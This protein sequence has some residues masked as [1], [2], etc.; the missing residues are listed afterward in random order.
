MELSSLTLKDSPRGI[1]SQTMYRSLSV[2][3]S[4][5]RSGGVASLAGCKSQ[6][7][8][9]LDSRFGLRP[10]GASSWLQDSARCVDYVLVDK[11]KDASETKSALEKPRGAK[12]W[13]CLWLCGRYDRS[14]RWRRYRQFRSGRPWCV[15]HLHILR[16]G[17]FP[18]TQ[19][20]M[21]FFLR[22]RRP[23]CDS[24]YGNA[25]PDAI[26][27]GKV[28]VPGE[29]KENSPPPCRQRSKIMFTI[30]DSLRRTRLA[31]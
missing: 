28:T 17:L 24:F 25:D 3:D 21:R 22:K 8:S 27:S 1:C 19:T 16:R 11:A 15:L 6:V 13:R 23:R 14:C 2:R 20:P 26:L 31:S 30:R 29:T 12:D 9:N 5:I 7:V 10:R 4:H 18:E